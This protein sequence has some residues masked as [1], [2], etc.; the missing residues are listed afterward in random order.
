[1]LKHCLLRASALLLIFT[2][3]ILP[4][5][6]SKSKPPALEAIYDEAVA[7]IA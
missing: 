1:M 3:L 6:C 7:L 4:V 5:G 2:L